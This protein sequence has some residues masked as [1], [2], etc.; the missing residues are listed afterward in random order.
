[1]SELSHPTPFADVNAVLQGFLAQIGRLLEDRFRAMYLYG[2]LALGD[3]NPR[4]SDIDFLVVTDAAISD[5]VF[6][7]LRA[8]HERFNAGGSPWADKVEAA[9]IPERVLCHSLP[10]QAQARYP[11]IEKGGTLARDP[12][13]EGW[14]FQCQSLRDFGIVIAGPDPK[15]L[16]D[17]I[18]P[19]EMRRAALVIAGRWLDQ[20]E[21]DAEWLA[22]VRPRNHQAFVVITLCRLLYSSDTGTVASK[23]AAGRWAHAA[24]D[25]TWATLIAHALTA[26]AGEYADE[27]ASNNEVRE[28]IAFIEVTCRRLASALP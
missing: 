12:L 14:V 20:A 16:I 11:Q 26:Q 17:P 10:F 1:M 19:N 27:E 2:S 22:W 24:L 21:H 15:T 13:E 18:N 9:Y 3:F 6:D 8:M 5:D 25:G 4:T 7:E 28:T 23:P